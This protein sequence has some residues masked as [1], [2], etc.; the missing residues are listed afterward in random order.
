MIT[1]RGYPAEK[2]IVQ[3]TDGYLLG[4]YRIPHGRNGNKMNKRPILLNHG[5][6][7]T[8]GCFI[9]LS[10]NRSI[11]F[12]LADNGYDVWLMNTRG[13][14]YSNRHV[15]IPES[16]KK[17][18]YD[19]SF[20]EIGYFDIP[21]SIDFILNKTNQTK[22]QYFGHS[23][24]GTTFLIM[25]STRPEYNQKISLATIIG[26]TYEGRN[27]HALLKLIAPYG[28]FLKVR[29]FAIPTFRP[30]FGE[31]ISEECALRMR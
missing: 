29:K 17:K 24:G 27:T 13:S 26:P 4:L 15:R 18:F 3:T 31:A 12:I 6:S 9:S 8:C 7:A 16:N 5:L 2:H 30:S 11:G 1:E 19:F 10:P 25:G 20:H 28:N 22:L 21:A 14:I 23:Q